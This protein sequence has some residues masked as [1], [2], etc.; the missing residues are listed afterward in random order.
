M[1]GGGPLEWQGATVKV[2]HK[3]RKKKKAERTKCDNYRSLS[4][5]AHVGKVL[6]KIVA[7]GLQ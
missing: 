5:V 1:K 3:N 4:L 7:N 2:L 6:L